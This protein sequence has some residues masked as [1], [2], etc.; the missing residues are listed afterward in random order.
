MTRAILLWLGMW[1]AIV[2][3][4]AAQ[5]A[6]SGFDLRSTL[7]AQDAVSNLSTDPPRS[8]SPEIAGFRAVFYPVWKLSDHWSV[9]GAWQLYSRPYFFE[10]LSTV[11]YGANGNLLQATL[12]YARV[13]DKGSFQVRA[14]QLTTAF[15]SFPLHY[16]DAVNILVDL[17]LEY[18]YY[19]TP[20]SPLG[21]GAVEVDAT[22]GKWDGRAQFAN[23]SPANPQSLFGRDQY[24]NWAGGGG[25]TVR[26]GFRIGVSGYRGPFLD[27]SND[28]YVTA[29]SYDAAAKPSKW[30]AHG[31]GL[32]VQWAR[33]HWTLQGELQRF[34]LPYYPWT[35]THREQAGYAEMKRTLAPRWY[36]AARGGY[37]HANEG[38]DV[39]SL[40]TAAGFRP[41]SF[42]L[43]KIDYEYQH[44]SMG[45]YRNSNTLAFQ[46]VTT[47]HF[48][49]AQR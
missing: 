36:I 28:G 48:S 21:V 23:S 45:E 19:G 41:D 44:M 40:E 1:T 34:V 25:F 42:Q 22:R 35:T 14:G 6:N 12:N 38:G 24:G 16:D 26:Q 32:D 3:I 5:E 29:G 31:L 4:L 37:T 43:I 17:P 20:V 18:G 10:D 49:A 7:S 2:Q 33:G 39:Q 30:P 46:V 47:L 15:G 11:G 9:S 27:R 13:S 8:A